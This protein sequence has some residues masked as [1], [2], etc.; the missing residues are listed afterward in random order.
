MGV[1][2]PKMIIN[3]INGNINKDVIGEYDEGVYMMK[4]NEVM[5]KRI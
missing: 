2:I 5:L 1:N 3:N 4:Y